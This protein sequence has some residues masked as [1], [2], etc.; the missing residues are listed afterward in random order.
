MALAAVVDDFPE[1][2]DQGE[3]AIIV[4]DAS[5]PVW[6]QPWANDDLTRFTGI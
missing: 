3:I 5:P 2:P 1:T 4:E 6:N